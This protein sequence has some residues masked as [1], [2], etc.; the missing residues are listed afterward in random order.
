MADKSVLNASS[1]TI[2]VSAKKKLA[3]KGIRMQIAREARD[4]GPDS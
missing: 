2:G 1:T 4:L 3:K